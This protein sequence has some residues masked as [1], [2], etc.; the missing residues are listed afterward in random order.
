MQTKRLPGQ[1]PDE[2]QEEYMARVMARVEQKLADEEKA[3]PERF[4]EL[5]QESRAPK[6]NP[7]FRTTNRDYGRQNMS[8]Y[9]VPT[10][11]HTVNRTFTEKQHLGLN[12]EHGGFN[13]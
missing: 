5:Q 7:I 4:H 3:V 9:E 13:L 2:T 10:E 8:Q 1:K 6:E 11:Y 12:Y